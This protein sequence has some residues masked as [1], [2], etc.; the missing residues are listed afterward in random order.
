MSTWANIHISSR[1]GYGGTH[2]YPGGTTP[3]SPGRRTP[4]GLTPFLLSGAALAFLPGV[5]LYGAYVYPYSDHYNYVDDDSHKDKSLPVVCYC[6]KYMDC[7]CDDSSKSYQSDFRNH[8]PMNTSTVQV[9]N[10]NGTEK[11]Y[12]NGTVPNGT[13]TA[14][15]GASTLTVGQSMAQNTGYW[16]MVAVVIGAVWM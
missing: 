2:V 14:S 11:I 3:Y 6:E 7:S 1:G 9:V 16:A 4:T 15:S 13:S 10:V 5:M 12:V 8:Q